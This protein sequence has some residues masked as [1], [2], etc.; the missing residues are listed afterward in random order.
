[1]AC[2]LD[3]LLSHS[4]LHP[5]FYM[6]C[7]KPKLGTDVVSLPSLPHVDTEGV[8]HSEPQANLQRM[9]KKLITKPSLKSWFIGKVPPV[10]DATW[11]ILHTLHQHYP[12]VVGKVL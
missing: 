12:H 10:E 11:E 4:K 6:S 1:M 2:K 8:V 3:L 7:W 9:M 5:D